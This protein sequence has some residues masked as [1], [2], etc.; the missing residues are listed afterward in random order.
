[1]YDGQR[2]N[3]VLY[4]LHQTV[5]KRLSIYKNTFLSNRY[6]SLAVTTFFHK[7]FYENLITEL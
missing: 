4:L 3:I 1:M 2:D 7:Q 6:N 5:L